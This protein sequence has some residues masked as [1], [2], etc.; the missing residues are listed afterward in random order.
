MTERQLKRLSFEDAIEKL[1]AENE[2]ITT[3]ETLKS[4]AIDNINNDNLFLAI[5]I[6]QG[7]NENQ[8]DYY[9]YD[10]CM[11]TLETPT[12]IETKEDL[13]DYLR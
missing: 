8:A 11:G 12:A 10:Y 13:K 6:L 1:S 4:F 5:H 3:Y 7:I 9:S 2:Q